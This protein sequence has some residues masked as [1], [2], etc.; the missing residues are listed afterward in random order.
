[1]KRFIVS[2]IVILFL[3]F[4][5]SSITSA[6]N[7]GVKVAFIRNHNLWIKVGEKEK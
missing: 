1:M 5:S 4:C 7:N 6:E 3:F 2:G